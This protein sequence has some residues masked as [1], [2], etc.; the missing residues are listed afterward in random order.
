MQKDNAASVAS[1]TSLLSVPQ[2]LRDRAQISNNLRKTNLNAMAPVPQVT[3]KHNGEDDWIRVNKKKERFRGMR[4]TACVDSGTKIKAADIQIP[5]YIYNI[6]KENTE[7][8]VAEYV[9]AKTQINI[10]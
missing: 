3:D 8:D 4:G 9:Y 6:S 1:V 2:T 10:L 5:L 7:H